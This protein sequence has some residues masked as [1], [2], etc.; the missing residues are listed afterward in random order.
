MKKIQRVTVKALFQRKNG[1]VM[2]AKSARDKYWELPGG[3]IEFGEQPQETL[4]REIEEE[5]GVKDFKILR[6]LDL[7]SFETKCGD[8]YWSFIA[9]IY[10]CYLYNENLKLSEEHEKIKWIKPKNIRE[11]PMRKGYYEA[12]EK[13]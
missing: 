10:L 6:P 3:K 11:I 5:L 9:A 7:F 12:I 1:E 13:L 2:V 8:T 4:R